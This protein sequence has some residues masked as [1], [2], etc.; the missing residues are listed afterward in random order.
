M[1]PLKLAPRSSQA[2]LGT[3]ESL[4]LCQLHRQS[5][6]SLDS[7]I[8]PNP[9]ILSHEDL[10][11]ALIAILLRTV[12]LP[13]GLDVS[14]QSFGQ[15]ACAKVSPPT[16]KP[17]TFTGT[18]LRTRSADELEPPLR[19]LAS[20]AISRNTS[21]RHRF[22]SECSFSPPQKVRSLLLT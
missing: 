2:F 19:A 12:S 10:I 15:P 5:N 8:T 6:F 13:F 20:C 11:T 22:C 4:P 16:T 21:C 7:A 14:S 18:A 17:H 3:Q 9:E 1:A